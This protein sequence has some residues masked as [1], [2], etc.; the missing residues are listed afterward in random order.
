VSSLRL[1]VAVDVPRDLLLAVDARL[2]PLR[3]RVEGARW[4][5]IENQHVTLR[6][7]G[8]TPDQRLAPLVESL[9]STVARHA[10]FAL[11]LGMLGTF[12]E[13]GKA[14]VL[15][16]GFEAPAPLAS[17]AQDLEPALVSLGYG[18]E[19]RAFSAHLTLARFKVP[20]AVRGL[21]AGVDLSDLDP[22]TVG[23]VGLWRSHLSPKGAR[24]EL[25]DRAP[26]RARS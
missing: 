16:A 5:P 26:L 14:R 24:Y 8:A 13:R 7:L 1:F 19:K 10:P 9:R 6:F 20:A 17:L 23:E 25:V 3:S 22:F 21:T 2:Q 15:W 12:P 11:Q 18:S 4:A